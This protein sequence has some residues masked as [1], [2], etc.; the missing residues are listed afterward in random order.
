MK[1]RTIR[2]SLRANIIILSFIFIIFVTTLSSIF[3]FFNVNKISSIQ[4]QNV[5]KLTSQASENISRHLNNIKESSKRSIIDSYQ[6]FLLLQAI[7]QS[8]TIEPQTCMELSDLIHSYVVQNSSDIEMAVLFLSDGSI[9]ITALPDSF[10]IYQIQSPNYQTWHTKYTEEFNWISD[11]DIES[12]IIPLSIGAPI[13]KI[14]LLSVLGNESSSL[15][16][17][18]YVGVS[19]TALLN[20]LTN[21]KVTSNS[22]FTIANQGE[23]LFDHANVYQTDTLTN[24]SSDER[25]QIR[26]LYSSNDGAIKYLETT[27][28]YIFYHPLQI[29]DFSLLSV[30]PLN[31]MFIDSEDFKRLLLLECM[32]LPIIFLVLFFINTYL[33]SNPTQ[34]LV[35]K[36]SQKENL[37]L[38]DSIDTKGFKTKEFFTIVSAINQLIDRTHK[39]ITSLTSEINRRKNAELSML[40][41]QIN[42]H[43]LYNTLDC[44]TQLCDL[45]DTHTAKEMVRSLSDFY[46]IGVSKGNH[47]ITLKE[48]TTH[49]LSYLNILELRFQDFKYDIQIPEELENLYIPKIILQPIVE[50]AIYHGIRPTRHTGILNVTAFIENHMLKIIVHDNGCGMYESQVSRLQAALDETENEDKSIYGLRNVHQRIRIDFGKP[51][52]ISISSVLDE[53]T[54]I[55]YLLPIKESLNTISSGGIKE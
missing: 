39:L 50:N 25:D 52:G 22:S 51:Y 42:P 20:E 46:R 11:K 55:S 37:S 21:Y 7:N 5:Q 35:K 34:K 17:F 26:S 54:T 43:F 48:E 32:L 30:I 2:L 9:C 45:N 47:F 38:L 18:L 19:D 41:A 40:Y 3:Y 53:G 44:I 13:P 28:N 12:S 15:Q 27:N 36:L 33:I 8:K 1:I 24:L 49:V 31:E 4:R 23:I 10:H 6:Y 29:N 14:G 16:G